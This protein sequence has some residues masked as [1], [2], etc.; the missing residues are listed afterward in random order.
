MYNEI[1]S[2]VII[3]YGYIA[4]VD[5]T[6]HDRV[7][8]VLRTHFRPEFLNRIDETVIFHAL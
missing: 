8:D 7:L 4:V 1:Q 6:H 2:Q 5:Q 3:K